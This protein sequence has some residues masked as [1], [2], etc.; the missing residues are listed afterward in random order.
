MNRSRTIV[1]VPNFEEENFDK[2]HEFVDD[3]KLGGA[4]DS[5]EG[6]EALQR[7]LEKLEGWAI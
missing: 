2:L 6:K 1:R 4:V 3:A 5:F 7:H